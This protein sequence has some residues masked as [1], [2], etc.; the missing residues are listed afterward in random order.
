MI[1]R[2]EPY[3]NV[4]IDVNIVSDEEVPYEEKQIYDK[5]MNKGKKIV[6]EHGKKWSC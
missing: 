4:E 1:V 6:K 2:N 5:T 3:F